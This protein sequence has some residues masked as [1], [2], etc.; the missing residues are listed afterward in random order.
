MNL[1]DYNH[2]DFSIYEKN[3]KST[4]RKIVYKNIYKTPS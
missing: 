3:S 1:A 2:R 4:Y